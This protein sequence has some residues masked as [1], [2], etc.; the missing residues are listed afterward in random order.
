MWIEANP[1]VPD[2]PWCK[3]FGSFKLAGEGKYPKTF[4]TKHQRCVGKNL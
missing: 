2:G 4:L 1:D 3:G